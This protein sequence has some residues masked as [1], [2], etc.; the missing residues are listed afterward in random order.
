MRRFAFLS[1]I[2]FV[3]LLAMAC[4]PSI[5]EKYQ[6]NGRL[7]EIKT[8]NQGE[9]R[10]VD[11]TWVMV[12]NKSGSK[13]VRIDAGTGVLNF[14]S[15]MLRGDTLKIRAF[16]MT[17]KGATPEISI[18]KNKFLAKTIFYSGADTDRNKFA[19]RINSEH[20]YLE[21]NTHV[22]KKGMTLIGTM[23]IHSLTFQHND[24]TSAVEFRGPFQCVIE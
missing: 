5:W 21:L 15:C 9:L 17:Q 6:V 13:I 3:F 12:Q 7:A 18:V 19:L 4:S 14:C 24:I 8:G 22:Y 16:E 1:M 11:S 20:Q 2:C 23:D 10:M